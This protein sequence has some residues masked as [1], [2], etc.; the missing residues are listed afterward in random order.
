VARWLRPPPLTPFTEAIVAERLDRDVQHWAKHGFG[1]WVLFDRAGDRFHGRA[2]IK[3]TEVAGERAVELAWAMLPA[4]RGTGLAG[5]AA[6]AAVRM[7]RDAGLSELVAFALTGND[8]SRRVME[9][10]G[11]SYAGE[12]EH[13]GLPHVLFR[14]PLR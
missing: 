3:W 5:E 6:A 13:A 7:A 12:I 8:A 11:M 9:K 14:L 4:S 10:L 1:L 2:G